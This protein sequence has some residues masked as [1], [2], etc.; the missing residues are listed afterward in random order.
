MFPLLYQTIVFLYKTKNKRINRNIY[1]RYTGKRCHFVMAHSRFSTIIS[2]YV[3]QQLL[4]SLL[5]SL[6]LVIFF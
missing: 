6:V 3:F 5:I 4:F 1:L 2:T